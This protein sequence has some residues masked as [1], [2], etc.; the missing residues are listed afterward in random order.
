M[1]KPDTL[2]P[3]GK[4]QKLQILDGSARYRTLEA[5]PLLLFAAH[6][7]LFDLDDK[8]ILPEGPDYT[9]F[10]ALR[11]MKDT[12]VQ[13]IRVSAPSKEVD[14]YLQ[15]KSRMWI[16]YKDDSRKS[17]EENF[18]AH[19]KLIREARAL[20]PPVPEVPLTQETKLMKAGSLLL[21]RSEFN[22]EAGHSDGLYYADTWY[23][24][25]MEEQY[26]HNIQRAVGM[27]LPSGEFV[28]SR[29]FG[30]ASICHDSGTLESI[31]R[32]APA[33]A[34]AVHLEDASQLYVLRCAAQ[35]NPA[36]QAPVPG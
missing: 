31:F 2:K 3:V 10:A 19:M 16:N 14:V 21:C 28:L 29:Q 15:A 30:P 1:I 26:R 35:Q 5:D 12:H 23:G 7:G 18:E 22:K 9:V 33:A 27:M 17:L 8:I 24:M 11:L 4:G 34:V 36:N 25:T 20:V 32:R 13:G 6:D